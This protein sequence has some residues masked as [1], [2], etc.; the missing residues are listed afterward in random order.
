MV[1][2]RVSFDGVHSCEWRVEVFGRKDQLDR[3]VENVVENV[4]EDGKRKFLHRSVHKLVFLLTK[5]D[6]TKWALK[7]EAL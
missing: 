1:F 2:G 3:K 6:N 7:N 4:E 5:D